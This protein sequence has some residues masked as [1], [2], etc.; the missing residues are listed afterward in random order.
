MA[1][2]MFYNKALLLSATAK[3]ITVKIFV[4]FMIFLFNPCC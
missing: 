2:P 1:T 3:M 4:V